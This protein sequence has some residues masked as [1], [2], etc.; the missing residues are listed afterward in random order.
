MRTFKQKTK[1]SPSVKSASP[2]R[3]QTGQ[4]REVN[5]VLQLQR[6][7]G[8]QA[9]WRMAQ[10]GAQEP[11]V[12]SSV[13]EAL[14]SP[15]QALDP[16]TR[17]LM[18]PRFGYDFS[19]VRMHVGAA[20][21]RSA[22]DVNAS[23]YTIGRDIV[24]AAGRLAPDTN[25]G[26]HLLAHELTHVVQQ[27]GEAGS[28]V[29]HLSNVVQRQPYYEKSESDVVESVIEA[30]QTSNKIAGLNVDPAFDTLNQYPLPFQ[31]RVLTQLY[32][33]GYFHGL[34]GYLAPGTKADRK[35]IVAIRLVECQKD[36]S[37]LAL[38][39]ILEADQFLKYD[40]TLP[41]ELKPMLECL[42][43]EKEAKRFAAAFERG[44][45]VCALTKGVMQWH[46]YSATSAGHTGKKQRMQIKFR[47]G[48][49]YRNKTVTF[50]QTVREEGGGQSPATVDI[51]M[52][53]EA[54]R[55]FYGANWDQA[56][57]QWVAS[58]EGRD[59]GFRSQP[60][61][62]GD[63][64]AYLFDEPYFFPPPHGRVFES[65]AVVPETGE[66][67]GALTWGVGTVPAYAQSPK[68]AETPS[69][70]YQSTVE[71]FYTPKDPAR[72]HGQ[73]NYDV[74]LDRFAANDAALSAEQKKQL[75]SIAARAK[76][77]ISNNKGEPK[78]T[79][80][81]LVIGAFGDSMDKDPMAAS[82]QRAQAVATYITS[83]GVRVST[84]DVRTF[85]ATWARYEVGTKKA[86][87]G[88]NRRVQIRLFVP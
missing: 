52:N 6:T 10:T 72:G 88:R 40:V 46:L 23:A 47:P 55:P 50:L 84:L 21:A 67:L 74:I 53:R 24:F 12:P 57:K 77:M 34:L 7:I 59:V 70:E 2:G 11:E 28:R 58:N 9:V 75:D 20:A 22:R 1:A 4:S 37:L 65:V 49:S 78:S 45:D 56:T 19:Q 43:R 32:D 85:G 86:Q 16:A 30:L 8:N 80:Q 48:S 39:E 76:E 17:G 62:A 60:S 31:V 15:G 68:C 5:S 18:E 36:P 44:S 69:S 81:H 42:E 71:K 35:L 61:T 54:F 63:P 73:E 25:E 29:G 13:H 38:E 41:S 51:G 66:V 64:A 82:E 79:D 14:R 33:R 27:F 83:K 87:E 3:L 26:Q